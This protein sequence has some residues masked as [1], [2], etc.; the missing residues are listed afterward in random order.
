M[1]K[2]NV[3]VLGAGFGGLRASMLIAKKLRAENLLQKYD[4]TLVDRSDCQLYTP[5]LYK[6]ATTE[7]IDMCTYDISMLLRGLPVRF[8]QDEVAG[9]DLMKGAIS[10]KS[11][12]N[13]QADFLVIA[14]GSETNFFGIPGLK[15][16]ALQLKYRE[17]GPEIKQAL[18][19]KFAK[20]GEVKIVVGG[21]GANGI[22]LASAIRM[23]ANQKQKRD[24][25]L[26]VRV[27]LLEA[28]PT[29]L[30]GLDPRVQKIAATRLKELGVELVVNAKITAVNAEQ[31]AL[32]GN[33]PL[34]FDVLV[35]TG[36]VKTP[37]L[38]TALPIEKEPRGKPVASSGME[39]LPAT[40]EL[41]F[42]PMVYGLG[43]SIC[44]M[45]AKTGRPVPAVA[46]AA[47]LQ[48]EVV[49]HNVIEEI[50]KAE[51]QNHKPRLKS[52]AP[53]WTITDIYAIPIGSN[54][55]V[56]KIGN[57]VFSGWLAEAFIKFIELDYLRMIM[58]IGQALSLWMT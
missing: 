31:I 15:E 52:F 44:F 5:F 46:R 8:L 14:L 2:K 54:W 3:V 11:G 6:A 20:S 22:E 26:R 24:K 39:C 28:M 23:M 29:V 16:N 18:E 4:V 55:A 36:G 42:A 58:P 33:D 7:K 10:M 43:D 41:K 19:A 21:A 30:P 13:L 37:D 40:P 56:A 9:F 50:K 12:Q 49:A 45:N 32:K 35:W 25:Q 48:A 38:L 51:N 17:N 47:I 53:T 1:D 57:F 27:T 34:P